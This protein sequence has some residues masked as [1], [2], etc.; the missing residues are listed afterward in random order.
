M[1]VVVHSRNNPHILGQNNS[2]LPRI[3]SIIA[4]CFKR[5]TL[6]KEKEVGKRMVNIV[7]QI[8]VP[9][10]RSRVWLPNAVYTC[11]YEQAAVLWLVPRN[12]VAKPANAMKFHACVSMFACCLSDQWGDLSGMRGPAGSRFTSCIIQC[13]DKLRSAR[14]RSSHL[15]TTTL[16]ITPGLTLMWSLLWKYSADTLLCRHG[17]AYQRWHSL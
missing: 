8:Q 9:V 12:F 11:G 4:D 7:R 13:S 1:L 14:R 2:N 6:D 5:E 17:Y 3:M 16:I 15:A 10:L